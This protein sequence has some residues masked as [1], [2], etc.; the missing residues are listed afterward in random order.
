MEAK[1]ISARQITTISNLPAYKVNTISSNDLINR[2]PTKPLLRHGVRHPPPWRT[3]PP[4]GRLSHLQLVSVP[5]FKL[6][7]ELAL[8]AQATII[9]CRDQSEE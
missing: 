3:L 7:S 6:Q 5:K 8:K 4:P 9:L 1:T 2:L